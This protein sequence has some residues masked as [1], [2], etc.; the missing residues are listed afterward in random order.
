MDR[1]DSQQFEDISNELQF[2]QKSMKNIIEIVFATSPLLALSTHGWDSKSIHSTYLLRVSDGLAFFLMIFLTTNK[3]FLALGND[4][5]KILV[6]LEDCVLKAVFD[7]SKGKSSEPVIDA[8]FFQIESLQNDL[9]NDDEALNWFKL[10]KPAFSPPLTPPPSDFRPNPLAGQCI[11]SNYNS[12][13]NDFPHDR[14]A[15]LSSTIMLQL[16]CLPH[17][18]ILHIKFACFFAFPVCQSQR[19]S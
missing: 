8:L 7:I 19:P 6:N 13:S 3:I 11:H 5:P 15:H 1:M 4:R 9:F 10:S 12:L 16:S 17:H 18:I 2:F 14:R